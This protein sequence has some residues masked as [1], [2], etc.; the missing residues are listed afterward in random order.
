[1]AGAFL[2]SGGTAYLSIFEEVKQSVTTRQAAERYGVRVG[3]ETSLQ[4]QNHV[5]YLLDT[6]LSPDMEERVAHTCSILSCHLSKV[7]SSK[8]I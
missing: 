3:R 2:I 5:D 4:K 6:L 1:M 8:Q 7:S